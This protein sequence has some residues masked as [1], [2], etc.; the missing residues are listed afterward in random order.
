MTDMQLG[1]LDRVK[2]DKD[3][4]KFENQTA[5]NCLDLGNCD[6]E[7]FPQRIVKCMLRLSQQDTNLRRWN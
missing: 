1:N 6:I 5:Y 4:F 3:A 7:T 2:H